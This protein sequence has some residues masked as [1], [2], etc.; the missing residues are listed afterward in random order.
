MDINKLANDIFNIVKNFKIKSLNHC[1]TRLRIEF[2]SNTPDK[3]LIK[4]TPNV[5][6]VIQ[7][8][9]QYQI[10]LGP[11]IVDEVYKRL[12]SLLNTVNNSSP[13]SDASP[14]ASSNTI[15]KSFAAIKEK[16]IISQTIARFA[17]IFSQ[18]IPAFV[19]AGIIAGIACII[20]V[21]CGLTTKS[22]S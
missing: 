3:D 16:K 4:K 12:N 10:I 18:L 22:D 5:I 21:S 15:P 13:I 19:G 7:S 8:G 20:Q 2:E 11:G 17:K 14:V 6:G 9:N 1:L